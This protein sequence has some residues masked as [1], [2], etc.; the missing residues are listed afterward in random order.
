M[1]KKAIPENETQT[2]K[3][4]RLANKRVNK[5]IV[6]LR[7]VGNLGGYG[8]SKE[9]AEKIISVIKNEVQKMEQNIRSTAPATEGDFRLA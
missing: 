4:V 9:Q 8:P 7:L 6:Q 3:L 5:T 1:A 2:Q